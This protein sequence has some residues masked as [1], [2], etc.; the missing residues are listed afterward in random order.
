LP[1]GLV[2]TLISA[3]ILKKPGREVRPA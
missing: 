2:V 1:V 3:L